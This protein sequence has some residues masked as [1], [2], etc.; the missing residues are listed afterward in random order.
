M[1]KKRIISEI[2]PLRDL[3]SSSVNC[4]L[5]RASLHGD[6]L[7]VRNGCYIKPGNHSKYAVACYAV[8]GGCLVYHAALEYLGLQTQV[9]TVL[10]V[11]S[12]SKFRKYVFQNQSYIWTP[13]VKIVDKFSDI[14]DGYPV[15]CTSVTQTMI[16]CLARPDLAGG[17]EEIDA[18]FEMLKPGD[19]NLDMAMRILVAYNRK[20]L[21]QR[22]GYYFEKYKDETGVTLPFL[23]LCRKNKGSVVST[24]SNFQPVVYDS[25]WNMM[26]LA[27]EDS[28][29]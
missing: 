11:T 27:Q 10:Q 17:Y 14:I 3:S 6:L 28:Y 12:P 8:K 20:S 22:V 18:A 21:W 1:D 9:S 5:S 24:M 15:K 29:A 13:H 19:I 26:V 23:E 4:Y 25:K 16:D 7:R 2:R